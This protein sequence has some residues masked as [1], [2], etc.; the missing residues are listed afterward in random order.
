MTV[1]RA[2]PL[3]LALLAMLL[4]DAGHAR[5]A[6]LVD[7]VP[8]M[9]D[10]QKARLPAN[11]KRKAIHKHGLKAV[12]LRQGFLK[13]HN[14]HYRYEVPLARK[15][16]PILNQKSSGRCWAFAVERVMESKQVKG[17]KPAVE[18][19]KSFINY[20]SLR[21]QSRNLL[22][23]MVMTRGKKPKIAGMLGE[24]GNQTRA[25]KILEQYGAVPEGK[26][27]TTADGANS[28]VFLSQTLPFVDPS[29]LAVFE[30][31]ERV[32]YGSLG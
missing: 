14:T 15:N 17:G 22:K 10:R 2:A 27:P 26:M 29:V 31:A 18:L 1:M 23:K 3:L 9:G 24:G 20:H 11:V 32:V 5:R 30:D 16:Q 13:R 4:P 19:S 25:M 21:H 28:G 12:A 6:A 8:A 7:R